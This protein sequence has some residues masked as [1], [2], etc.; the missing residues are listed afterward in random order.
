LINTIT[1]LGFAAIASGLVMSYFSPRPEN[2][3]PQKVILDTDIGDDVDDAYALALLATLSDANLLGV[4]T[5]FGETDK[6]AELAAKLLKI[7]RRTDVPVYAG[8]TGLSAIGRQYDWAK[9]FKSSAIRRSDAIEF[10]KREIE[11]A[12]GEVIL[13]GIGPL[14]NL[15]DLLTRFP[16]IKPQIKKIV[17][18]AGSVHVGYHNE[19][20]ACPEWNVE[21]DPAA[22][23]SVF[24]SGVTLE[25][26]PLDATISLKLDEEKQKLLCSLGLPI[27]DALA[28]LT[29]LWGKPVP[30]LFDPMAIAWALGYQ[31]CESC[32]MRIE[33]DD[34]GYTKIADGE[35]NCTVLLN[36]KQE[37]FLNWYIQAIKAD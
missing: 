12:P 22:A 20:P 13:I 29:K 15:G 32:P 1:S 5:V 35:P 17:L 23:R 11:R 2:E 3:L 21:C 6:R 4:T 36:P 7:L 25:I 16:E 14:I 24:A 28:A 33:V 10:M 8:R 31:F 37:E 26:A 30:T 9:G 18:M 19:P 27:T 34:D